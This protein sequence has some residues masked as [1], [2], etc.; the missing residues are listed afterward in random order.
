[1]LADSWRWTAEISC[2]EV[3]TPLE[4]QLLGICNV[5]EAIVQLPHR[6]DALE[7]LQVHLGRPFACRT[8]KS[9]QCT[10]LA[11]TPCDC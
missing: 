2:I 10:T 3:Q 1:M 8:N 11:G 6:A 7:A 9:V 4:A 5:N